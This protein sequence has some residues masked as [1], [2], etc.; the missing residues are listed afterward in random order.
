MRGT[1]R[2]RNKSMSCKYS[3]VLKFYVTRFE[4][5]FHVKIIT[6]ITIINDKKKTPVKHGHSVMYNP[7]YFIKK[8]MYPYFDIVNNGSFEGC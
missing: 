2:D 3:H 4:Y 8:Y 7:I 5:A 1:S 6:T